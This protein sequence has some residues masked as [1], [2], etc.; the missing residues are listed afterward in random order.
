EVTVSSGKSRTQPLNEFAAVSARSFS[1]E[2]TRRYAA[3]ISDPARMSMNFAGVSGNGDL[4]NDI[5]VRGNSPR[6][7]LWKLEGIEIPNPNHFSDMGN[8]GGAIS[9]LNA[10]TMTT[11]DFYTGAFPPEI[12]NA[13]SGAFDLYM[14]NGNKDT[15]EQTIEVSNLG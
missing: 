9:M 8:S 7:V 12:G 3:S 4:E 15:R 5:V 2:E 11:S 10:N 6:G 14:R 13:L 1:V